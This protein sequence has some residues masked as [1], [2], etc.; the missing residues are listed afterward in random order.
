MI[1]RVITYPA[2]KPGGRRRGCPDCRTGFVRS[3]DDDR[4]GH[5]HRPERRHRPRSLRRHLPPRQRSPPD[6]LLTVQ[7]LDLGPASRT[8]AGCRCSPVASRSWTTSPRAPTSGHHH[9]TAR[10]RRAPARRHQ[11]RG[12]RA[13][14][15]ARH[16]ASD[17]LRAAP[18]GTATRRRVAGLLPLRPHPPRLRR[19]PRRMAGLAAHERRRRPRRSAGV[20]R[21]LGPPTPRR[22]RR[23]LQHLASAVRAVELLPPPRRARP[24]RRQPGRR[25]A[26]PSGD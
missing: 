3:A 15:P 8:P 7:A 11:P 5:H 24:D 16:Q 23:E 13:A 9:G 22:R 20:R 1:Q 14:G 25:G 6:R 12:R 18:A 2:P 17:A 10:G 19:R 26:K 21:P 4:P